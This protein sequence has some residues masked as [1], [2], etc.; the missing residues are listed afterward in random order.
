MAE[1]TVTATWT[2]DACGEI[3]ASVPSCGQN[4]Q[5]VLSACIQSV[6]DLG[7]VVPGGPTGRVYCPACAVVT[8]PTI[9][10]ISRQVAIDDAMGC[11]LWTGSSDQRGYG[12]ISVA[13]RTHN[14]YR[15]AYELLCEPVPTG[16][17]LDHLCRTPAC[18]NPDHLEPVTHAENMRRAA[19]VRTHCPSGHEYSPE[20]THVYR[21]TRICRT[22]RQEVHRRYNAKRRGLNR[23]Y[24]E[25]GNLR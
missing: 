15:L 23:L 10:R 2:C 12:A 25:K 7:W 11:W 22:C 3:G 4:S 6:R 1:Y 19:A 14:V 8:D 9:E 18:L 5:V 16:L 21:G 20:N 24:D 17:E 13:G